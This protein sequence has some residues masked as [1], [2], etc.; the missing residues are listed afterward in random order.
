MV[1][2]FIVSGIKDNKCLDAILALLVE[3]LNVR[4]R[5]F[6]PRLWSDYHVT[7]EGPDE[8]RAF[9]LFAIFFTDFEFSSNSFTDYPMFLI[10]PFT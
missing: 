9:N 4:A 7:L 6:K 10:F 2:E 5:Y 1:R 8:D 3:I